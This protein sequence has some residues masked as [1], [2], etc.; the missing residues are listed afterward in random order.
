M[1]NPE[2]EIRQLKKTAN[3]RRKEEKKKRKR[4]REREKK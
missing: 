2:Y 4:E 1:S 3:K